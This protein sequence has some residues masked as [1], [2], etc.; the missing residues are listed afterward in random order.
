MSFRSCIIDTPVKGD[1]EGEAEGLHVLI[2]LCPARQN[3]HLP[4]Q[5]IALHAT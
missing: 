4:T 5:T 2:V 3:H 1:F